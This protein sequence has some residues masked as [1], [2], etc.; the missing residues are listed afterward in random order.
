MNSVYSDSAP[1]G[2]S[3]ILVPIIPSFTAAVD[4]ERGTHCAPCAPRVFRWLGVCRLKDPSCVC[5]PFAFGSSLCRRRWFLR[6]RP[7]PSP[8]RLTSVDSP[9]VSRL[10]TTRLEPPRAPLPVPP[11]PSALEG[12]P[13]PPFMKSPSND[14]IEARMRSSASVAMMYSALFSWD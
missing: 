12:E 4:G 10:R 11:P 5:E 6:C 2:P 7:M 1:N 9:S 13:S 3:F 8:S 14:P